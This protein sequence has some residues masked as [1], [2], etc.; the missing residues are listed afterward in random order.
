MVPASPGDF[1]ELIRQI[2]EQFGECK[3]VEHD[4]TP[5]RSILVV[6][7]RYGAYTVRIT[8]IVGQTERK[9]RYYVLESDA[10][11]AG[12]DNAADPRVVQKKYGRA[13]RQHIGELIPHLHL[14]N[15]SK[16]ELTEEMTVGRFIDWLRVHFPLSEG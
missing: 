6:V 16:L 3:I 5:R 15:K 14:E 13:Y 2:E 1:A 11:V 9:Y 12:F 10:V 4:H 8:E 7:C